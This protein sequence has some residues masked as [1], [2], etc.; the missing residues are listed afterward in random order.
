M[1]VAD[2]AHVRGSVRAR[3]RARRVSSHAGVPM[4]AAV[5]RAPRVTTMA[6]VPA[7]PVMANA[8]RGHGRESNATD[9]KRG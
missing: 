2:M 1:G 3:L 9:G 5:P 7:V 4:R 6:C 8:T